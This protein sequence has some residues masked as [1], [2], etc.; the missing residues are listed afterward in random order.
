MTKNY[1]TSA[2]DMLGVLQT[3]STKSSISSLTL[4][5]TIGV[6]AGIVNYMVR[7]TYPN[8][9]LVGF[10]YFLILLAATAVVN[11]MVVYYYKY[12]SY[13]IKK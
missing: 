13:K 9:T 11:L 4:I 12:K 2:N 6:V 10:Y 5:T 1:L 7:D 8:I 3:E